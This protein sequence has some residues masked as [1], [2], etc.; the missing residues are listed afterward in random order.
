[1]KTRQ[2]IT[3]AMAVKTDPACFR[4][5]ISHTAEVAV[6]GFEPASSGL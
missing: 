1:V 2:Q 4:I 5:E 3:Y 6:T